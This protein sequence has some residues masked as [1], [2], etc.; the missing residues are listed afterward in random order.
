M[1]IKPS[2]RGFVCVT[3]HPK[4]CEKHILDEIN[5]IR[6]A[7]PITSGAKRVL[8]IGASA[9]YGLSSRIVPTYAWG[10]KTIGVFFERPST[11]TRLGTA[12]FYNSYFFK[13]IAQRDGYYAE[14]INGDA[15]SNDIKQ[16]TADLIEK[17]WG[18]VDLIVYSLAS[19][20]RTDPDTG[21]VYSSVIK[22]IGG[23]VFRGKSINTD[24]ET[25]ID[26]TIET[27][28][29]EQIASTIKVM[30]G[31]DWELWI[32]YLRKRGLL[33]TNFRTVAYSYIGPQQTWP[34]YKDGTI[35]QAKIDLE[36]A[37]SDLST[38]HAD[39]GGR[40]YVS[41]NKAVVTQASA[42]IPVV[43]LYIS[44]M[45]KVMREMGVD[46]SVA[47]QIYRL[48][49][50]HLYGKSLAEQQ[51]GI[52]IRIDDL[53]LADDVQAAILKIWNIINT[54]NLREVSDFAR[55]R[56]EFLK[57]FGFGYEGVDYDADVIAHY[58]DPTLIQ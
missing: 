46:E 50:D 18:Q 49:A 45:L 54:E 53:E 40:A 56:E 21:E 34:I 11:E 41:V 57:L 23:E 22:P 48:Y 3:C 2:V 16:K 39:V 36:R 43:P 26:A 38:R 13:Q 42:A 5:F 30:G 32:D 19:P 17:D 7:G 31:Q 10:A 8:V 9:G 44:I 37:A 35:G 29:E 1:I 28:T 6:N 4:G 12:G 58:D 20:R 24:K 25:V 51:P 47:Q 55:Y 27:A 14:N 15:F 33:A 52:R